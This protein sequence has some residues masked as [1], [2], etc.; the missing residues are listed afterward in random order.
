MAGDIENGIIALIAAASDMDAD[1]IT[2]ATELQQ[3]EIDSLALTEV[4][5]EIEDLHDIE[6]DLNAAEAWQS[7]KTV[8]DIVASVN[9]LVEARS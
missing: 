7:L 8:G 5:M 1:R 9:R 3:L 6:I 4:I 2:S